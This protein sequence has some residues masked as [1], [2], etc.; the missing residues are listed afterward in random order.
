MVPF[1]NDSQSR[2]LTLLSFIAQ[3]VEMAYS[4][5]PDESPSLLNM[6]VQVIHFGSIP[7]V[8]FAQVFS[9]RSDPH[10]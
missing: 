6:P 9:L 1:D 10:D 2:S 3:E 8:P 7:F 5:F 4:R